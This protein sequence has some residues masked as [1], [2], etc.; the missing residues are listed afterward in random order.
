MSNNIKLPL[1]QLFIKKWTP[2][3]LFNYEI[4][5]KNGRCFHG[6]MLV[7]NSQIGRRGGYFNG[8]L[9]YGVRIPRERGSKKCHVYTRDY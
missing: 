5:A 6:V 3:Q 2:Y 1:T 9:Q 8:G 4:T 7:F